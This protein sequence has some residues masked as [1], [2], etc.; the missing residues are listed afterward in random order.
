MVKVK[1]LSPA[2]LFVFACIAL[3]SC[4][5][6]GHGTYPPPEDPIQKDTTG[7]NI[8]T[9][10]FPSPKEQ[11]PYSV[12]NMNQTFENFILENNPSATDIPEL[13]PNFL[14]VRFLP[15]GK[16]AEYELK[17]KGRVAVTG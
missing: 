14:Y 9:S 17:C 15:Y 10:V 6:F 3:F 2:F 7:I 16:K 8:L 4:S 12:E 13:E 1:V 5:D 11:N